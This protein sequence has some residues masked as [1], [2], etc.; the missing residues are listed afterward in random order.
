MILAF[1]TAYVIFVKADQGRGR[2]LALGQCLNKVTKSK[3]LGRM[4]SN[5]RNA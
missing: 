4:Q 2:L 3:I 1:T 5:K